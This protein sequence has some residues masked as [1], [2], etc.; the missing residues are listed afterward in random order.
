MMIEGGFVS[1]PRD[2][3]NAP[4]TFNSVPSVLGSWSAPPGGTIQGRFGWANPST[5]LVSNTRV[6]AEDQIGI[7]LPLSA[8]GG[9]IGAGHTW[10][11]FD[12]AV[13]AFRIRQGL[14][15][16]LIASG[17]MWLRFAGGAYT[18]QPIYASLDDGHAISG[19]AANS[20]LTPWKVASN[21]PGGG[22]AITSTN[23][24]FGS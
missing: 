9:V 22:L 3:N 19:S 11:F 20:E 23:A 15:V 17:P 7:V 13:Q 2:R 12:P 21:A 14:G 16:T 24:Y 10:Q 4:A 8:R 5:G 6:S 18:G 1:S